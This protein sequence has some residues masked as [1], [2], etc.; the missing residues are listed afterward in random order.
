MEGVKAFQRYLALKLHFTSD[1]DYFQY[2]GKTRAGSSAAFD[3]RKDTFFFRKL[4]RRYTDDQLTNFFVAN[5]VCNRSKWVGDLTTIDAEKIYAEWKKRIQSFSYMFEQDLLKIKDKMKT[6]N[7]AELWEVTD[8]GHPEILKM[9]LGKKIS[10]ETLIASNIVLSFL[11]RW[12]R[13][14]KDTLIWPDNSRLIRKYQP[15]IMTNK[16]DLIKIVKK[17]FLN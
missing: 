3:K 6:S 14:I 17:V 8:G 2:H 4:E 7:P 13:E 9:Y 10:I 12:D 5:F 16:D 15:F 11:P 1:Y